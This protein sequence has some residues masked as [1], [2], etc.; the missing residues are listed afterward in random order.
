[1]TDELTLVNCIGSGQIDAEIDLEELLSD[2]ELPVAYIT[3]PG[4]YFKF[5][6]DGP[7]VVVARTGKY[8]FTGVDSEALLWKMKEKLLEF[9][10]DFG[11]IESAKD[12]SFSIKNMVFTSDLNK[13][14][15]LGKLAVLLGVERVEYEPEQFP[16]L[17]Y[18]SMEGGCVI[19][20][21][22]SGK[23]VVTGALNRGEAENSY[24][25]FRNNI[26]NGLG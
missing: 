18:R 25:E 26:Q 24:H 3:G 16:G 1:M 14:L 15:D 13:K 11:I 5:E 19:L 9:F 17:I 22:N 7:T 20:A 10:K 12:P 6:P 8:F 4:L 2:L 23:V 21:F